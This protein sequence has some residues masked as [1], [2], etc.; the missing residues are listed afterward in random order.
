MRP[1]S[2]QR[3]WSLWKDSQRGLRVRASFQLAATVAALTEG[4]VGDACRRSARHEQLQRRPARREGAERIGPG[5]AT[6]E[7]PES[8]KRG[9]QRRPDERGGH[10]QHADPPLPAAQPVKDQGARPGL[11]RRARSRTPAAWLRAVRAHRG[12]SGRE[13]PSHTPARRGPSAA[14]RS[15]RGAARGAGGSSSRCATAGLRD[16][17]SPDTP[18]GATEL[19]RWTPH[20]AG[21]L[22]SARSSGRCPPT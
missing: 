12:G 21:S 6:H 15:A 3:V 16:E 4:G 11:S 19:I 5:G 2:W 10:R 18:A 17:T 13:S 1:H 7:D 9:D 8:E 14:R 20:S 22:T